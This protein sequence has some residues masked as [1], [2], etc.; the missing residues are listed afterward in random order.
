MQS[1]KLYLMME[2]SMRGD[3]LARRHSVPGSLIADLR[4]A[5][6][7]AA[8]AMGTR[9]SP[10]PLST[11]QTPTTPAVPKLTTCS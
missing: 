7:S 5:A 11:L 6:S 1:P 2:Q 3:R 10:S 8:L 9:I 4:G